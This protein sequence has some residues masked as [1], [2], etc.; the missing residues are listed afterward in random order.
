[1]QLQIIDNNLMHLNS[2]I[3]GGY[4]WIQKDNSCLFISDVKEQDVNRIKLGYGAI[5]VPISRKRKSIKKKVVE[6]K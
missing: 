4:E 3:K 1:M 5:E 6:E 2:M